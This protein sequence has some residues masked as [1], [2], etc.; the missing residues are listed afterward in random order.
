MNED[1]TSVPKIA[2]LQQKAYSPNPKLPRR[3]V[4]GIMRRRHVESLNIEVV[5]STITMNFFDDFVDCGIPATVV[6]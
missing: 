5:I 6:V 4:N 3:L 2:K 1:R